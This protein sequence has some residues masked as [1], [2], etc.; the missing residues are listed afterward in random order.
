MQV[1][2]YVAAAVESSGTQATIAIPAG[3]EGLT[4]ARAIDFALGMKNIRTAWRDPPN[5]LFG[6]PHP[7]SGETVRSFSM[8]LDW[9]TDEERRVSMME[10]ITDCV[11]KP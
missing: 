4:V 2:Q 3:D 1:V 10:S 8:L 11:L 7:I 5:S 9:R 6:A